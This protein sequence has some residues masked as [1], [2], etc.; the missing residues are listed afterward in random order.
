MKVENYMYTGYIYVHHI[1]YTAACRDVRCP[2]PL[3]L[4][5]TQETTV[6]FQ[7]G[8]GAHKRGSLTSLVMFQ[9]LSSEWLMSAS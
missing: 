8:S 1:K 4:F 7:D 5:K 3:F 9:T 6:Q 2:F